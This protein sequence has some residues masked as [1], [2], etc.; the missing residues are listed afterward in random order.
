MDTCLRPTKTQ[1]YCSERSLYVFAVVLQDRVKK[2]QKMQETDGGGHG[3]NHK[4]STVIPTTA[5]TH[6]V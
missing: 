2:L 6:P 3:G 4:N 1:V 5:V